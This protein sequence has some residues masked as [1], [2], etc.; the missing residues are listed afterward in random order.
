MSSSAQAELAWRILERR[1]A[2]ADPLYLVAHM[3]GLDQ[4]DGTEFD[5][6]HLRDSLIEDEV[7]LE[8]NTLRRLEPTWRWQR[9]VAEWL[10]SEQRLIVLKGRQIGVTWLTLAVDV[11]EAILTPG[12]TSLLY[13]QREDEAIDNAR[14]WWILFQSLP[15]YFKSHITV[16]KPDRA[17]QPGRDGIQL[18]FPDGKISEVVPMTSAKASGHGRSVRRVILDEAA[19]IDLL[20][21]IRAAVEPAA[22]R[23]K[24][25]MI[26]TANGRS[27]EET[28][29][30]NEFHRVWTDE[31]SGYR[32]LF[33]PYDAHP[34][35]D[36]KWYQSAPEVQ[37]LRV[38]QRNAQFPRDENEAFALSSR[39]F[40]APED[41]EHYRGLVKA[42][43]RR[44][45]FRKKG[46]R[47]ASI[48]TSENGRIKVYAEPRA[49]HSYAIGAD[50]ATGRGRDRSAAFVVDLGSLEL[51][52]Q[53]HGRLDADEFAEQLYFL[54]KRYGNALVAVETGGGYGEPVIA[55][56]RDGRTGRPPYAR[57][58][59]HVMSSRPDLAEAKP[60]GF[61]M[62]MKTRPLVLNQMERH[63]REHNLP[64]VTADLLHE[65]S[66]FVYQDT[67]TSPRALDGSFDDLVM[68]AAITLEMYRLRGSHPERK[69][70][71]SKPV[72]AYPWMKRAA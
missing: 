46:P 71:P 65:M 33:L 24:I 72:V 29:E 20:S 19:H 36:E 45:D 17:A 12:S 21:D 16:L 52:A 39:V 50:V 43:K 56:L 58:Y 57:L 7:T 59:R 37:S 62:N 6:S 49:D 53:F 4:R 41:I 35:R 25:T 69:K 10:I 3:V 67:G 64:W 28:G 60:F 68:A 70:R 44:Y 63:I 8:E 14:R 27:N 2:A 9:F 51:C 66:S 31:G 13:R 32:K 55:A 18:Q 22:G 48:R 30:G 15:H 54:G 23:A 42:P 34:D 47:T 40:F 11:A 26:S 5:F 61:P 38:H 1:K